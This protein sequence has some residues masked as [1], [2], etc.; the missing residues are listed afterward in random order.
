[1]NPLFHFLRA[2]NQASDGFSE[3]RTERERS[4]RFVLFLRAANEASAKE[5]V[6]SSSSVEEDF[7]DTEPLSD[8]PVTLTLTNT[9]GESVE[10]GQV[11]KSC[12]CTEA[13]V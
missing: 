7:G 6:G 9:F 13:T 8:I 4:K 12:S 10:V 1:M 5:N 3:P 2:A 11:S